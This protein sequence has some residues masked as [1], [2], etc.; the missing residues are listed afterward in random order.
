MLRKAVGS[1]PAP[2]SKRLLLFDKHPP[3]LDGVAQL[4]GAS[5]S[6]PKGCRFNS[7]SGHMSGLQAPSPVGTCMGSSQ[8]MFL[9]HVNVSF[10]L[11]PTLKIHELVLE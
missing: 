2:Y 11:P 8:S 6:S 3:A 9:S 10:S 5:S 1:D 4:V 7:R